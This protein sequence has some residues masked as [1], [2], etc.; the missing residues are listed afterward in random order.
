[1]AEIHYDAMIPGLP[2]CMKR[3]PHFCWMVPVIIDHRD[4]ARLPFDLKAA[5]GP[6]KPSK[7][8]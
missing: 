6:T 5:V 2:G 4:A 1:M 8:V 3:S 7:A